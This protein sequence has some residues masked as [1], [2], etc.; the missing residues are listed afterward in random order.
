M[1]WVKVTQRGD[2]ITCL[3]KDK[4]LPFDKSSGPPH[5]VQAV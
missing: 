4:L 3:H 5:E 2:E 1:L